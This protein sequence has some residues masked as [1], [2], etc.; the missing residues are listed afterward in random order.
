MRNRWIGPALSALAYA[1]V[2]AILFAYGAENPWIDRIVIGEIALAALFAAITMSTTT[3]H[4]T[5]RGLGIWGLMA[6]IVLIFAA[7]Q[8]IDA[9][10]WDETP[11][12][13][14]N[15]WRAILAVAGP[16]MLWGYW[17]WWRQGDGDA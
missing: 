7:A 10:V 17:S 16:C 13:V 8:L 9:G 14:R 3:K 2:W 4:W 6:A 11:V 1:A 5:V 15:I 12:H